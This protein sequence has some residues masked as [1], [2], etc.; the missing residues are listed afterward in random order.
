MDEY[1]QG[2]ELG[3]L[4]KPCGTSISECILFWLQLR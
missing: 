2:P 4:L 1:L 3:P